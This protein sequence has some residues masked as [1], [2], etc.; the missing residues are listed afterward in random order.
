MVG[1][2]LIIAV[3]VVLPLFSTPIVNGQSLSAKPARYQVA[4]RLIMQAVETGEKRMF[5]FFNEVGG[6]VELAKDISSVE[7]TG[8]VHVRS[9]VGV[10]LVALLKLENLIGLRDQQIA[11]G[12]TVRGRLLG[13]IQLMGV[14][15]DIDVP[16]KITRYDEETYIVEPVGAMIYS[17]EELEIEEEVEKLMNADMAGISDVLRL[18]FKFVLRPQS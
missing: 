10:G 18:Y 1:L 13:S 14:T 17:M 6:S 7:A 2:L 11:V 4:G 15:N 16:V 8:A 9:D 3:L 5:R 12:N